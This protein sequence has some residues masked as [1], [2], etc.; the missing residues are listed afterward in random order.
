[1]ASGAV[2]VKEMAAK[3]RQM[4]RNTGCMRC[5]ELDLISVTERKTEEEE[6]NSVFLFFIDTD[7]YQAFY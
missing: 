7:N 5:D 1:V 4:L 2:S 6:A 3:E